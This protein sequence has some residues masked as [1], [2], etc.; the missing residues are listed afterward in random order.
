[1]ILPEPAFVDVKD[2]IGSGG[3]T[4]PRGGSRYFK[5]LAA[6][7]VIEFIAWEVG[8]FRRLTGMNLIS[9]AINIVIARIR[10]TF[11]GG[12]LCDS[13]GNA[14]PAGS[15]YASDQV[16][17]A[18]ALSSGLYLNWNHWFMEGETIYISKNQASTPELILFF[19]FG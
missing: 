10:L 17:Y 8:G 7:P 14:L 13:A 3:S 16:I 18:G 1:M 6:S 4:R 15:Q 11:A 2:L 9:S 19:D 5:F 12:G